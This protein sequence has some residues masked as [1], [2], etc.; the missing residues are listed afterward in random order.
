MLVLASFT[1]DKALNNNVIIAR[2]PSLGEVVLI[3][4]GIGFGKKSGD[5]LDQDVFEK[6]FVLK[7]TKEQTEYKQLLH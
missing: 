6:M 1:V 4:K 2:H 3:G 5:V 7:N